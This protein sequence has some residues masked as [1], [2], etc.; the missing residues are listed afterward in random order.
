MPGVFWSYYSLIFSY[1]SRF[2]MCALTCTVFLITLL[3]FIFLSLKKASCFSRWVNRLHLFS[4][5]PLCDCSVNIPGI[6]GKD[7]DIIRCYRK[8]VFNSSFL[9][10][11]FT[12][13]FR[14]ISPIKSDYSWYL[15]YNT[16][17][18]FVRPVFSK[19]SASVTILTWIFS[20]HPASWHSACK[21][22]P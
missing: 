15:L 12:G 17:S 9:T 20:A 19:K 7:I 2:P 14:L 6:F 22:Y 3:L 16:T 11:S 8:S 5:L 13:S 18:C 1:L 21:R 4:I 10:Y